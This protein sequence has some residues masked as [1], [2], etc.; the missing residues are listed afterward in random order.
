MTS[1]HQQ[2]P[3]NDF[4]RTLTGPEVEH[5]ISLPPCL[6]TDIPF[7]DEQ[8][9]M[10]KTIGA[11]VQD[12]LLSIEPKPS[13]E[14]V[15]IYNKRPMWKFYVNA[16]NRGPTLP[17][18]V[19]GVAVTPPPEREERAHAVTAHFGYVNDVVGGVPIEE[20]K[21]VESWDHE[22][23]A[24]IDCTPHPELFLDPLGFLLLIDSSSQ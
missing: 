11:K 19:Y 4:E 14:I 17:R 23:L 3:E 7:T 10:R 9:A 2:T 1:Q 18:R 8:L 5:Y 13:P 16:D 15:A 6:P 20:L 12:Y 21:E 24:V 22:S